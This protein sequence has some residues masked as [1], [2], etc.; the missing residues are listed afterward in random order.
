MITITQATTTDIA[1]IQ[2]IAHQ[3]WPVAYGEIISQE[4][5]DYM[6]KLM[7]SE[8][9]LLEQFQNQQQF[10]IASEGTH[11]LGFIAIEHYYKNELWTKIHKIYILP[12]AQ[13]KG[14]GKLLLDKAASLAIE[15]NLKTL[16]LNV[17]KYNNAVAFYQ[18]NGFEIVADEVIE[19]GKGYIMDDYKMEKKL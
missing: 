16:S 11:A 3:T 7:Y 19:I 2:E 18:K 8:N 9:A 14:V 13:G 1:I 15:N 10:F 5:L 17:N 12:E 4:Q 6:L